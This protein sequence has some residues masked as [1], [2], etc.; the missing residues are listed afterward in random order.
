MSVISTQTKILNS[1][2]SHMIKTLA[3]QTCKHKFLNG[4]L[5]I[6]KEFQ[7]TMGNDISVTFLDPCKTRLFN[8][9]N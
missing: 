1:L 7:E 3:T 9:I 5:K 6:Y 2:F 4:K 8:L